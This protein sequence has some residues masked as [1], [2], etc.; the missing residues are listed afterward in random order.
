M[1]AHTPLPTPRAH[2]IAYASGGAVYGATRIAEG[3]FPPGSR[4]RHDDDE[5]AAILVVRR[6]FFS[7]SVDR[8]SEREL[9]PTCRDETTA[10]DLTA[11]LQRR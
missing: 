11:R 5:T 3:T 8:V 6:T 7:Q 2:T 9:F 1:V 10:A 4:M